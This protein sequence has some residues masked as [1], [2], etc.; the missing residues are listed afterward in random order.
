MRDGKE[1]EW[2]IVNTLDNCG[3]PN[4]V[5][6]YYIR[7]ILLAKLHAENYARS[8][9][10]GARLLA[11]THGRRATEQEKGLSYQFWLHCNIYYNNKDSNGWFYRT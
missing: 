3:K 8:N 9:S 2:F 5:A 7:K 4:K 11:E 1:L 10:I 6:T